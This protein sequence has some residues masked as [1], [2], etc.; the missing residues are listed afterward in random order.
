LRGAPLIVPAFAGCLMA[1]TPIAAQTSSP[2]CYD[3]IVSAVVVRQ[4]PTLM[5]DCDDCIIISWPWF[6]D[7]DVRRVVEGRASRG[8]LTVLAVL[9]TGYRRDLGQRRWWLRRNTL[10]GF[11]LLRFAEDEPPVRCLADAEPARPYYRP[12]PDQTL[13]DVRRAAEAKNGIYPD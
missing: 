6:V 11:N 5:E 12:G 1:A 8:P 3:A 7:L 2:D 9:H 10:G 4:Q 13:T